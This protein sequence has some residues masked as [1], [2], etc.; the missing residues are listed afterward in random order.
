MIGFLIKFRN[1][2]TE[3]ISSLEQAPLAAATVQLDTDDLQWIQVL[4]GAIPHVCLG[5]QRYF[6]DHGDVRCASPHVQWACHSIVG[7]GSTRQ[8]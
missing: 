4:A 3:M 5:H 2:A 8:R 6:L 7:H 1:L